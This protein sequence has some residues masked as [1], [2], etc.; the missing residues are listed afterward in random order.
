VTRDADG[1]A[2]ICEL[3]KGAIEKA[4]FTP[5]TTGQPLTGKSNRAYVSWGDCHID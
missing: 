1:T 4:W 2:V 5:R 3:S